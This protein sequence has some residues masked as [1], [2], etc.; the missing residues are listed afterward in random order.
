MSPNFIFMLTRGDRTVSDAERRVDEGVKG[1]VTHLGFKDVGLPQTT[2]ERVAARIRSAGATLYMEVVS[3][4]AASEEASAHMAVELNVNVLMG[5]THAE[6]VLPVIAGT[7]IKY[8]PFPGVVVGHPSSLIGTIDS[9]AASAETLAGRQGVHGLD[10]LAY[11][12]DG[13]VPELIRRVCLAAGAKPVIVA[14]SLD[15]AERIGVA[16]RSGAA[17]FT[18]GTAAFDARFPVSSQLTDQLAYILSVRD[19]FATERGS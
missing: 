17:A 10:L 15:S 2:L 16:I 13:A 18:V 9:I 11:R 3:L 5:G 12:F 1:G 8:Y 7:N 6:V 19:R 4:D 14:G